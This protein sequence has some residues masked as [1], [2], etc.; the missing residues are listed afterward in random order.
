MKPTEIEV[1]RSSISFTKTAHHQHEHA[2]AAPGIQETPEEEE[3]IVSRCLARYAYWCFERPWTAIS[4][5]VGV[6][7]LITVIVVAGQLFNVDEDTPKTW[8]VLQATASKRMDAMEE[9]ID[10]MGK[11][12]NPQPRSDALYSWNFEFMYKAESGNILTPDGIG[13]ILA[14]EAW[15][16][17]S[18]DYKK[19][20]CWLLYDSTSTN[21]TCASALSWTTFFPNYTINGE[22]PTQAEIDEV[23]DRLD[24]DLYQN[25]YFFDSNFNNTAKSKF[26]RTIYYFGAPLAGFQSP[27][28]DFSDQAKEVQDYQVDYA[29]SLCEKYGLEKTWALDSKYK[30]KEAKVSTPSGDVD[31]F[32]FSIEV[33]NKEIQD[34]ISLD[35]LW[36]VFCI[37]SVWIYMAIHTQSLMLASF[38]MFEIVISFPVTYF[39]YEV[40]C[41]I[42]FFQPVH[43]LAIFVILGIGAD[44]VFV[45]VDAFKQSMAELG[46]DSSHREQLKYAVS[47]ASQAI[48]A[49]SLTTA[50]AFLATSTSTIM[51]I[52]SFGFFATWLIMLLFCINAALMPPVLV[53]WSRNF[54]ALPC[55]VCCT[56]CLNT[57]CKSCIPKEADPESTPTE[58]NP[59]DRLR[60]SER[61][62]YTTFSDLIIFSKAKYA[63]VA[64]FSVLLVLGLVFSIQLEPPESQADWFSEDHFI[65]KYITFSDEEFQESVEDP[66][67]EVI[68]VWGLKPMSRKGVNR[69]DPEDRG[70]LKYDDTFELSSQASQESLIKTCEL[71]KV[72]DCSA[73]QCKRGKLVRFGE[74]KCFM[75]GFQQWLSQFSESLP[76]TPPEH[77]AS[78]L[79][80]YSMS[81]EAKFNYMDMVG[82]VLE[83]DC[84]G[85]SCVADEEGR[86]LKLKFVRMVANSTFEDPLSFKTLDPMKDEWEDFVDSRNKDSPDTINKAFQV[87]YSWGWADTQR[88]LVDTV[89]SGM[90]I[91]FALAFAILIFATGNLV[92]ALISIVTIAGIVLTVLGIGAKAIMGWSLDVTES[93]S[94]VILI[95]LSVDYC[96][97]LAHAY[98]ESP[99]SK[100]GDRMRDALTT[101]GISVTAGAVTTFLAGAFLFG[102]VLP[103][104]N[105][106]GFIVVFTVISSY[107]WSML[108]FSATCAI[109]G[110]EDEF[111]D[112]LPMLKW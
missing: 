20:F 24:D 28:D 53:I 17:N 73:S 4:I 46:P 109:I 90:G 100:R 87:S 44:D 72:A 56:P 82:F 77:F 78:R 62:F 105:K 10:E 19:D 84:S 27:T 94:A 23:V 40:V 96:V 112:V 42:I 93:I 108:F 38:G 21:G 80:N 88:A 13:A 101:M 8:D 110:P 92:L 95:G 74:V 12:K 50:G 49:T 18:T 61:F 85:P 69:W 32:W 48:F 89:I 6:V 25:G 76:L 16:F 64:F 83:E 63:I 104:F 22:T 106:F 65:Q 15:L 75:E 3:D 54:A 11:A 45:F 31:I 98:R 7:M 99:S 37:I 30:G 102:A 68:L 58:K 66:A 97:H 107:F 34:T 103:F 35:F 71:L 14:N 111:G 26:T 43:I 57:L 52:A 91:T 36:A 1:S 79:Y 70:T 67:S 33:T 59:L 86:Q 81:E 29:D 55:C 60:R 51:P 39:F 5:V 9:A 41:R 47:R 2:T